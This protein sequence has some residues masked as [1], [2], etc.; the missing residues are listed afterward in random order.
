M[1]KINGVDDLIDLALE[2]RPQRNVE[3]VKKAAVRF[4][5]FYRDHYIRRQHLHNASRRAKALKAEESI[6][7]ISSNEGSEHS[8]NDSTASSTTLATQEP[9]QSPS[10][11]VPDKSR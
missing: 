3:D 10:L 1:T 2:R 9:E 11:E 8:S 4:L 5:T 6:Q 7:T